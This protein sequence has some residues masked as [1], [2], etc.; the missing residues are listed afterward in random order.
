MF[1]T[2]QDKLQSVFDNLAR[3]GRLTENDVNT[4]LR[5]VRRALLEAD[6]NFKVTKDLVARI[7]ER[8]IGAEVMKSLTPAQQVVKIVNEELVETLGE[9]APLDLGGGSPKVIMLLGLQGAGKTTMAAKLAL[10]LRRNGQR[11]LMVAADTRRPAAIEQLK[12]LGKELDVPVYAEDPSVPPP[13]ICANSLRAAREGAHSVVI[14]DTAGRLQIDQ[15]LMNELVDVK[16]ETNPQEVLLV[17]DAMTGP[18]G[19]HRGSR[20]Q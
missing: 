4:A 12:V 20:F 7:K 13:Q 6:V 9:A 5:E 8:A 2:L 14:L 16:T 19:S 17:V 18:R 3:H 10:H 1:E 11:P 15:D